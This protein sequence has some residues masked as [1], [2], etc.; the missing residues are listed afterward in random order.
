MTIRRVQRNL[1]SLNSLP[2]ILDS[3]AN[4]EEEDKAIAESLHTILSDEEE[5]QEPLQR[6]R[7]LSPSVDWLKEDASLLSIKLRTTAHTANN[8]AG[9]VRMLDEEMKRVKEAGAY[10]AQVM[11]LKAC[12]CLVVLYDTF[13]DMFTSRH[14][15][16]ISGPR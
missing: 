3:L 6:L 4:L 13:S 2:E 7:S 1:A 11:E 14:C 10:V 16:W 5:V 9:R 8:V 15:C 12:V